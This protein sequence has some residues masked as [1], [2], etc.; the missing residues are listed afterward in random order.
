MSY[1]TKSVAKLFGIGTLALSV[2]SVSYLYYKN[3]FISTKNG[4]V[5]V[6]GGGIVG[7]SVCRQLLLHNQKVILLEKENNLGASPATSGNSGLGC[8]GYDAPQGSLERQLLRRS[9]QLHPQ[10]YK[11][12]G[13]SYDHVN[14]CGSLVVAWTENEYE[15]LPKILEENYEIGDTEA[16][17]LSKEELLEIESS[18]SSDVCGAIYVPREVISEP[19]LVAM[20]YAQSCKNNGAHIYVNNEVSDAHYDCVN[21]LW[22]VITSNGNIYTAPIVINCAGLYGDMIENLRRKQFNKVEKTD[23][24]FEIRPRKGQF[25]VYNANDI[26]LN[27]IIEPVP[28]LRTKGVIIWKTV[29]GNIIV[30]P[31]ADEQISRTDRSN[32]METINMLRKYGENK[33]KG[34]KECEI[35][36]SYSGIRPS[37][38]Y[39]DYQIYSNKN[40]QWITV[41]GIRSTGLTASS[42][43]GE[44][45]GNLYLEM[46]GK[47]VERDFDEIKV[48]PPYEPLLL[49]NEKN[50]VVNDKV[51]TLQILAED[52][53]I[54]NNGKVNLYN[55]EYEVTHPIS[56]FGMETMMKSD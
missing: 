55:N 46:I 3:T 51:P 17:L 44:Y 8:T 41:G 39:R 19:W 20:G 18:L 28:T 21:K 24:M 50:V 33:I 12:F 26:D 38:E 49:Q 45:V 35:I 52:F 56:Y 25:I 42:G 11:S 13:L 36:G 2:P 43:I 1:Q 47:N 32:D 22:N 31:T 4:D 53:R 6:I 5:I 23:V 34:L 27:C 16:Q 48:V 54:K 10:L 15:K 7:L 9:I 30:G 40:Q 37:T 14:K 29:Y